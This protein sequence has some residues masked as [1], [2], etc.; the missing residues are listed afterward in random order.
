MSG[1]TAT[2]WRQLHE[3]DSPL[4]LVLYSSPAALNEVLETVRLVAPEEWKLIRTS[5]VE[6]AFVKPDVPLLLTPDNEAAAVLT[7]DGRR[8]ALL[9]RTAPAILFLLKD[10]SGEQQLRRAPGLASWLQGREFDPEPAQI[11]VE[12]E[13]TRFTEIAGRSADE[14]L[15]AWGRGEIPDT[16]ENSFLYQRAL[17]LGSP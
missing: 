6:D 2:L 4:S 13:R 15:E 11:D 5:D 3:P 16:L 12:Q 9:S 7:L 17:L 14:W 1:S 8:E 10:G